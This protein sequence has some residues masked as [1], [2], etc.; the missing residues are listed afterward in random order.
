MTAHNKF[1]RLFPPKLT[2]A[3]LLATKRTLVAQNFTLIADFDVTG[4]AENVTDTQGF[5]LFF[6]E[7]LDFAVG[8]Y[9]GIANANRT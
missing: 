5:G 9:Y 1:I 2:T 4:K 7:H 8:E 6:Q 3:G